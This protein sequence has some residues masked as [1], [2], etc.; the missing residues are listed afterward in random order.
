MVIKN[1]FDVVIVGAGPSG[2]SAAYWLA[3]AGYSVALVEKKVFPREKTCGDGL[4]PR[5]VYQLENM[6]LAGE[7][8]S[9]HRFDGLRSIAF[10][11]TL[12]MKWPDHSI[13][14]SYGYVARRKD[15]DEMVSNHAQSVGATL[16]MG[17]E[18]IEP[19]FDESGAISIVN[20]K[21]KSG[22]TKSLSTQY[23]IVCEGSTPRFGRHLGLV[24][25]KSYPMGIAIRGYFKSDMHDDPWIESHLDLVDKNGDFMPG[26]GWIFPV[27]DGT[28]NVGVGLLSTFKGYKSVNTSHLYEQFCKIAPSYW[29]ISEST[30]CGAPTGG[31]LPTGGSN[32]PKVGKNWVIAGDSAGLV[33]PFNGEGIAYGYETGQMASEA[34][35]KA[36]KNGDPTLLNSYSEA[37]TQEFGQYYKFA[38]LFVRYIGNPRVMREL[39]R[40]G[41]HSKPLMEATLRIM[42]NLMREDD[43]KFA[44]YA[45]KTLKSIVAKSNYEIV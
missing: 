39:V 12:E 25:D 36:L 37:L 4:T 28:I 9:F 11:R 43:K 34:I 22:E 10:G 42:A 38:R 41:M 13:L 19:D 40:A 2:S 23:I 45:Y 14:P 7:L 20:I 24:R 3:S 16:F 15:L 35:I 5:A 1:K 31:K 27:G 32:G 29:G 21:D 8:T 44:E 30:S 18:A 26:Y 33:N 6:G 17:Y